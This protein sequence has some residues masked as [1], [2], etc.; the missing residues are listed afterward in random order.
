MFFWLNLYF[1]NQVESLYPQPGWVE[2]DPDA[3]WT[4]FVAVVK[5]AV[6]GKGFKKIA[7]VP[8]VYFVCNSVPQVSV[9]FVGF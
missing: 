6:K 3:L 5:G 1:P 7:T 8:G 9:E 2:I 4:Q